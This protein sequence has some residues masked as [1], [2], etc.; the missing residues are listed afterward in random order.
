VDP[1]EKWQALHSYLS[2]ARRALHAGDPSRALQEVDAALAIDPEFAAARAL[3]EQITTFAFTRRRDEPVEH[4]SHVSAPSVTEASLSYRPAAA[5]SDRVVEHAGPRPIVSTEGFARFEERARRRRIERRTDA[6]REA[7]ARRR[8]ADARAA[9][10]E[11]RTL[12]P[13]M[14]DL[15]ALTGAVEAAERAQ[16]DRRRRFLPQ[17]SQVAAA[18]VFAAL[19]LGASWLERQPEFIL[20]Y[21]I[22]LFAGIVS[23]AQPVDVD[24]VSSEDVSGT[25]GALEEPVSAAPMPPVLKPATTLSAANTVVPRVTEPRSILTF[26]AAPPPT[27]AAPP[28]VLPPVVPASNAGLAPISAAEMPAGPPVPAAEVLTAKLEPRPEPR[29]EAKLEPKLEPRL[30]SKLEPKVED[31]DSIRR[32]LQQYRR[33]YDE[34]DARLARTVWPAVNESALSRAF[35]GLESQRLTFENCDIQPNSD[36]AVAV[37]RGTAQYVAKVG[38]REPRSEPRTWR[39]TLARRG[40]EWKI[41]SARV[42]RQHQ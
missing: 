4:T 11:I 13:N 35:D 25:G 23:T 36:S 19:M 14:P 28:P 8:F 21:P 31:D 38:S 39:F 18:A 3:R 32:A 6:A 30:D 15:P 5:L 20:S 33:A 16:R 2:S 17:G 37:C 9:I 1:R 29:L 26:G 42:E 7:I 22:S 10:D 24:A 40:A 41:E 12:D 34:L 27:P